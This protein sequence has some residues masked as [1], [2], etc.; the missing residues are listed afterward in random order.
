MTAFVE[1]KAAIRAC[2]QSERKISR[3][4]P[5]MVNAEYGIL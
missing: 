5:L 1:L 3:S 2:H 4:Q